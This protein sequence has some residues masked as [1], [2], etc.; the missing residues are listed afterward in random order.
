MWIMV[1]LPLT[2][3]FSSLCPV[4]SGN[5]VGAGVDAGVG[6]GVGVSFCD[7]YEH[8]DKSEVMRMNASKSAVSLF[9]MF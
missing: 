8:A 5:G 4:S 1:R 6:V 7:A 3:G 9:F 2:G